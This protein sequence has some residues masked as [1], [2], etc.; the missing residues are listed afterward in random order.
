MIAALGMAGRWKDALSV[1]DQ[2]IVEEGLAP[3]SITYASAINACG[4]AKQLDRA[5]GLLKEGRLAG[6]KVR[7]CHLTLACY[8]CIPMECAPCCF[9]DYCSNLSCSFVFFG[10][11]DTCV[12]PHPDHLGRSFVFCVIFCFLAVSPLL[13]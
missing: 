9:T 12:L 5:L 4:K 2:M 13:C 7:Y 8:P 1:M 11:S 3:N 10:R 6:I